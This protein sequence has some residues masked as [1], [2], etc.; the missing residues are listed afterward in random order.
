VYVSIG[1]NEVLRLYHDCELILAGHG[2]WAVNECRAT[3]VAG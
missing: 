2:A 3:T 1:E